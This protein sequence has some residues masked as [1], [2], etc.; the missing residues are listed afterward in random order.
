MKVNVYSQNDPRWQI[1]AYYE[2]RNV[3]A[4]AR[5]FATD[6]SKL[7]PLVLETPKVKE[8]YEKGDL[9]KTENK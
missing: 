3:L 2:G 6:M 5:E 8:F 1:S 9:V 4:L 7:T